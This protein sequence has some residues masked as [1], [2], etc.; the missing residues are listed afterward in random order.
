MQRTAYHGFPGVA[1]QLHSCPE[2]GIDPTATLA[3]PPGVYLRAPMRGRHGLGPVR[4]LCSSGKVNW[5]PEQ[6]KA[7]FLKGNL[8]MYVLHTPRPAWVGIITRPKLS[9]I[10]RHAGVLLPNG[11]VA[12]LTPDGVAIVTMADFAQGL[13]IR[14]GHAVPA[15]LHWQ[16]EQR[17]YA[18]VGRGPDYHLTQF[19]CEV[20]AAWLVGDK[21]HS[22]QVQAVVIAGL[23]LALL[24][25]S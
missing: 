24:K 22:P 14:F 9:G 18:S 17:A 12:H 20:Y 8:P 3:A 11:C 6:G 10:G 23:L 19:N 25:M 13:P 5:A 21:P 16:V 15:A 7:R 4:T 2:Q 1:S